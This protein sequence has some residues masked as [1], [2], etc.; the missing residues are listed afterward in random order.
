MR[1]R[2]GASSLQPMPQNEAVIAAHY[3]RW[4]TAFGVSS[5]AGPPDATISS[6]SPRQSSV[7]PEGATRVSLV[8]LDAVHSGIPVSMKRRWAPALANVEMEY[9]MD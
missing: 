8:P 9:G 7:S 2:P 3:G 4:R 6:P 5:P 1:G